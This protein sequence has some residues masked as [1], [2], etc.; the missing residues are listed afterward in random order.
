[1]GSAEGHPNLFRF[2]PISSFSSDLFR[3]ALLVP[4]GRS[5]GQLKA[6]QHAKNRQ[7]VSKMIVDIF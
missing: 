7:T 6:P 5:R 4:A 1:M 2:V 3:F